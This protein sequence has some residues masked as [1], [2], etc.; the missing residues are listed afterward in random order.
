MPYIYLIIPIT[1]QLIPTPFL[2]SSQPFSKFIP[3]FTIK[4]NKIPK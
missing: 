4:L 2:K 1:T 3:S